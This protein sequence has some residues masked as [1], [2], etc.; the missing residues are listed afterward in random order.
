MVAYGKITVF[1]STRPRG[2]RQ[3]LKLLRPR[4][5]IVSIHAPA[6]G[7]TIST[8][9]SSTTPSRFNPRA[10]VGRDA[11]GTILRV[12][13]AMFQSTRPRGARRRF[14]SMGNDVTSFNPR[15]RV[16]RDLRQRPS[17]SSHNSFNPRARVGRDGCDGQKSGVYGSFQSTRP[18]GARLVMAPAI[19]PIASFQSTR[20]RGARLQ[21]DGGDRRPC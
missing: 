13:D 8:T 6:W 3:R 14:E 21:Q 10:R 17:S 15:A 11:T 4:H 7:A 5:R 20:P 12:L 19:M 2:A 9:Q 16:G 1:Q 18:R